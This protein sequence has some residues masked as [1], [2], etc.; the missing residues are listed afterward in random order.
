MYEE[1]EEFIE[2][3]KAVDKV[4]PIYV[5]VLR[6]TRENIVSGSVIVM[7][8]HDGLVHAFEHREDIQ[9]VRLVPD[10]YFANIEDEKERSDEYG[11]YRAKFDNFEESLHKEYVKMRDV[12]KALGFQTIYNAHILS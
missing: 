7:A 2:L 4:R 8:L 5:T 11:R 3:L 6:G 10:E 1:L 9:N 12:L